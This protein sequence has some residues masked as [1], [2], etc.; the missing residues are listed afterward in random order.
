M[1]NGA[2]RTVCLGYLQAFIVV[3]P[4]HRLLSQTWSAYASTLTVVGNLNTDG[5]RCEQELG[6]GLLGG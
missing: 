4:M 5:K 2:N 1:G 3:Y 6:L